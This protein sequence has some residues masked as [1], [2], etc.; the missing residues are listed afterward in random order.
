MLSPKSSAEPALQPDPEYFVHIAQRAYQ[1]EPAVGVVAP[2]DRQLL[3]AI[4]QPPRDG[5]NLY[6][7][8]VA[9]DLLP[10]EQL[11]GHRA[12]KELEPALRVLY[13]RKADHRLHK[14]VESHRSDAPVER[15]RAFNSGSALPRPHRHIHARGPHRTKLVEILDRHL[16]VRVRIADDGTG[17]DGHRLADAEPLPAPRIGARGEQRRIGC[18]HLAHDFPR[19][20]GAI[21]CH[22]NLVAQAAAIEVADSFADGER[23]DAGLIVRRQNQADVGSHFKEGSLYRPALRKPLPAIRNRNGSSG[24]RVIPM[25]GVAAISISPAPGA[26]RTT[27]APRVTSAPL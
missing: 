18:R 6:V 16:V 14:P 8:H 17:S 7:E 22:D 12:L 24:D 25:R 23:N 4:P 27:R 26:W 21:R 10:P 19:A 11:L 20:V 5:Q 13:P 3:D 9:V 15:L 2:V 1:A